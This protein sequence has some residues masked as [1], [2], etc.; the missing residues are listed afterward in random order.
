MTEKAKLV[1]T[2]LGKVVSAKMD[3]SIVV[4]VTRKKKHPMGKYVTASTKIHAHDPENTCKEGD[5]VSI[6]QCR[7]ISKLKSWAFWL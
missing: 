2:L 5:V 4:L 6:K 3:K 7:P 1:R